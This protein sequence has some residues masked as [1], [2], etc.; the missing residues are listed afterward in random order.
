VGEGQGGGEEVGPRPQEAWQDFWELWV[1]VVRVEGGWAC[2]RGSS[3]AVVSECA[4][5]MAVT[6]CLLR[7][8]R[9]QGIECC[10]VSSGDCLS[11]C[12][13]PAV[14]YRWGG[15][16]DQLHGRLH[17][18]WAAQQGCAVQPTQ[19]SALLLRVHGR[20]YF[21]EVHAAKLSTPEVHAA[22]LRT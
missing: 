15:C 21:Y 2:W 13:I 4:G 17:H 8:L 5:I 7:Q 10:P 9:E 16:W 1:E 11:Q 14:D 3:T 12:H 18:A 20:S 6:V 19:G 22:K